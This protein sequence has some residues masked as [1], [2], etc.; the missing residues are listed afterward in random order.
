MKT[1]L[2]K[3]YERNLRGQ[4]TS[5]PRGFSGMSG[6]KHSVEAKVKIGEKMKIRVLTEEHKRKISESHK[7]TKNP[8]YGR[9]H[10][11][12]YKN[13]L[14]KKCGELNHAWKGGEAKCT[15]CE[16]LL[17]TRKAK[18]C[19]KHRPVVFVP[20]PRRGEKNHMWKGGVTVG[21]NKITY[22]RL[23]AQKRK[24]KIRALK[25]LNS[26]H[27]F[28]EWE[29][30]KRKFDYMCLCC[31]RKEPEI[32]LTEDHI[33]PISMGGSNEIENIQPLCRSC[34]SIKRGRHI[35]YRPGLPTVIY[36]KL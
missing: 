28:A 33:I 10:S 23:S 35:D 15:V 21:A 26:F 4:F 36:Q 19:V 16:K 34:N 2:L 5:S 12:K 30:L 32:K 18:F 7:G 8:M 29:S 17:A 3:Q 31:K 20:T 14:Q 9:T 6:K 1:G 13:F 11:E 27:T 24:N 25:L 22:A